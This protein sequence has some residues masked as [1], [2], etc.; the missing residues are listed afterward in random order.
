MFVSGE[1]FISHFLLSLSV[2]WKL[3]NNN[4]NDDNEDNETNDNNI[5]KNNNNN[6]KN[7]TNYRNK[8]LL[9]LGQREDQ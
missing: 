6:N 8:P 3:Q 1:R 9:Q 4:N 2:G 5:N 7:E